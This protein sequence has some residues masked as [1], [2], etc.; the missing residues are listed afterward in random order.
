M[1]E[2]VLVTRS[3]M[4]SFEEYAEEIKPL[5]ETRW[6]T[7]S[8]VKH[9][10]L[11]KELCRYLNAE[12][13]NL[14]V[15]GHQALEAIIEVFGLKGE[16]VTTPFTFTSTTNSIVRKGLKPVFC[17]IREDDFTIDA[18][19]I[20]PLI[21]EKTS[22]IIPV[23]VYGNICQYEKIQK[24]ADKYGLKVIYDAAHA[25]GVTV[26]GMGAGS[27]GDASMF[28]FHATKV[29]H[30]IEGGCAIFK[31]RKYYDRLNQYKNFGLGEDGEI[32]KSDVFEKDVRAV[33]EFVVARSHEV[34]PGLV[35]HAHDVRAERD[36]GK[37]SPL[38]RVARVYEQ[39]ILGGS[40]DLRRL[41]DA[42][43]AALFRILKI[44]VHVIGGKDRHRGIAAERGR[45][46]GIGRV[47]RV[48]RC[49]FSASPEGT[50]G[51]RHCKDC[52]DRK[53]FLHNNTLLYL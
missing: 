27:L 13:L 2:K 16:A 20:E 17:D 4:P 52:Q 38:R 41:Y 31:E 45:F 37:G 47:R 8:G 6:I 24:I 46:V 40:L 36:G 33:I 7:N 23:H 5:W 14:C 29:F 12:N 26:D 9:R 32:R 19:K 49:A 53:K 34:V 30:T 22:A 11:E 15:N 1:D 18:D 39:G 51:K 42:D 10:E 25:F 21:T 44:A 48:G 50:C 43:R 3:S 28:S 35:H